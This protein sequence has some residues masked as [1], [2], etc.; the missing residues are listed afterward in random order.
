MTE[1]KTQEHKR[2][3]NEKLCN[4]QHEGSFQ[5]AGIVQ[6]LVPFR[7]KEARA[8]G[9]APA[10]SI[11]RNNKSREVAGGGGVVW[12]LTRRKSRGKREKNDAGSAK[13]HEDVFGRG[14]G[15]NAVSGRALGAGAIGRREKDHQRHD[16]ERRVDR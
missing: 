2:Q 11:F 6:H 8:I 10:R 7:K 3:Q 13:F 14:A 16:R 4:S 5:D 9:V 1:R 12:Y 15:G